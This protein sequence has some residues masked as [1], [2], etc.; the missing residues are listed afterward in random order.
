MQRKRSDPMLTDPV[1]PRTLWCEC[2][3]FVPVV[4][5]PREPA[6]CVLCGKP[7]WQA[8]IAETLERGCNI[9]AE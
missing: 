7:S 5:I 2:A 6:R 9:G 8:G 3:R 1:K 4:T